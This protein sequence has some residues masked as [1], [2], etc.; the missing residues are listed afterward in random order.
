MMNVQDPGGRTIPLLDLHD[1]HTSLI[2]NDGLSA[3]LRADHLIGTRADTFSSSIN[4]DTSRYCIAHTD[5]SGDLTNP[6]CSGF[7]SRQGCAHHLGLS[8]PS[9]G[10]CSLHRDA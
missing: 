1:A 7:A 9:L 8:S 10:Y 3:V 5:G 4:K 2:S 6:L